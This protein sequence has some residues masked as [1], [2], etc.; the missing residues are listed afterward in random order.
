MEFLNPERTLATYEAHGGEHCFLAWRI[1]TIIPEQ[2]GFSS[3]ITDK[4]ITEAVFVAAEDAV[5]AE[6]LIANRSGWVSLT[7]LLESHGV[8]FRLPAGTGATA[9][10]LPEAAPSVNPSS[11]VA[12]LRRVA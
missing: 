6:F 3:A 1:D 4:H 7:C 5:L 10:D 8:A 9:V 11:S 2:P 12:A